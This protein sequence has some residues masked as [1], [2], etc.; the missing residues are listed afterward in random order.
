MS[1]LMY[2][3]DIMKYLTWGATAII[4]QF[5]DRKNSKTSTPFKNEFGDGIYMPVPKD[6]NNPMNISWEQAS[7]GGIGAEMAGATTDGVSIQSI[8]EKAGMNL[9]S[10]AHVDQ[11]KAEAVRGQ[12]TREIANPYM[13]MNFKSI[14]F[15]QFAMEFRFTPHNV[16]ECKTI[17]NI[18]KLFRAVALP[19]QNSKNSPRIGYP[20]EMEI[21][22][23]NLK[24]GMDWM[25]KFKRSVITDVQV[26]YSGQGHFA[27]LENGFPAETVLNIKFTEN[28]LVFRGDIKTGV[29]F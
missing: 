25:P 5:Y 12:L 21:S 17:D 20:G 24:G 15:R 28:E 14:G 26:S 10:M 27:T 1:L 22:Y 6:L 9:A 29:S 23:L 7:M 11:G 16:E 19:F 2:P 13:V 18:V 3:H 4:F 8:F